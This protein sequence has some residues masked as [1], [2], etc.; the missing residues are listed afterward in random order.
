MV[1]TDMTTHNLKLLEDLFWVLFVWNI[2]L[3]IAVIMLFNT[4]INLMKKPKAQDSCAQCPVN[5][6]R[7]QIR[8]AIN[9]IN[10]TKNQHAP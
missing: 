4:M 5:Q 7:G 2:L 10:E 6:T 1:A 8:E 3:T 9:I